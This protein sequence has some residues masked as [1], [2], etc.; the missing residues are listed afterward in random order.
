MRSASA[1]EVSL[2]YRHPMSFRL[3]SF[4]STPEFSVYFHKVFPAIKRSND[5]GTPHPLG[6]PE[7]VQVLNTICLRRPAAGPL[8]GC[9]AFVR[10]VRR[11]WME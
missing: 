9:P 11:Y 1:L 3:S 6:S 10:P 8:H 5:G 2:C 4:G 7:N